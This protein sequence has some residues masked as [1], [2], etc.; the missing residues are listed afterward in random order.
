[1]RGVRL[2]AHQCLR[3][4]WMVFFRPQSFT[5]E[6]QSKNAKE[7][8][9]LILQSLIVT[10]VLPASLTFVANFFWRA[11]GISYNLYDSLYNVI[12]GVGVGIAIG[13]LFSLI[14]E[15][16]IGLS[17]GLSIGITV[18]VT[19][20]L[21]RVPPNDLYL[22]MAVGASLGVAL[23]R[24]IGV[25]GDTAFGVA[26]AR[27]DGVI[28]ALLIGIALSLLFGLDGGLLGGLAFAITSFRLLLLPA[29][30]LSTVLVLF[31]CRRDPKWAPQLFRWSLGFWDEA[32]LLPQPFLPPLLVT[33]GEQNRKT[34]MDAIVHLVE[35]TFQQNAARLALLKL[36]S[37]EL[38]QCQSV[39]QIA[40]LVTTSYWSSFSNVSSGY[41]KRRGALHKVTDLYSQFKNISIEVEKGLHYTSNYQR[42]TLYSRIRKQLQE[43]QQQLI[44]GAHVS[45]RQAFLGIT[46]R[47]LSLIDRE[48]YRL[49]EK[50]QTVEPIP[51][52]YVAPRPLSPG[53]NVFIGRTDV[54]RFIENHILRT[55]QI[56]PIVLHGQPRIGKSSI[57]R[58][59]VAQLP[60][61]TIPVYIDMHMAAQVETTGGLLFN[62][63]DLIAQ[64]LKGREL[65]VMVPELRNY[66][67]EPFI[68]FRKFLD[69]VEQTLSVADSRII[70]ALDEF[71]E[72]EV[73]L[74]EG[75]ISWDFMSFLRSTMQHRQ[76]F[77]LLFAGTHTLDEMASDQWVTY[78]RSAVRCKVS[79]LDEVDARKLIT[80]PIEEFS[81]NYEPEA[82][83]FLLKQTRCHPCLIQL[84]CG[85]LVNLKNE[86]LSRV[87]S[88]ADVQTALMK[89]LETGDY[90]FRGIWEWIPER[91][92]PML[93]LLGALGTAGLEE[94]CNRLRT[95]EAEIRSMIKRL[96][97]V[98]I[99]A[100]D[101]DQRSCRFHV[102][103]LQKWVA[104]HAGRIGV[105]T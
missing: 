82:V 13:I 61:K 48:I 27:I 72:I 45:E 57:L 91:E 2:F 11:V 69:D 43:T 12:L 21:L 67:D 101:N 38:Q 62:L 83:E 68:C 39:E 6:I 19:L 22:S 53:A 92:R 32:M 66:S 93:T 34:G 71:E 89:A 8:R 25:F 46:Q 88:V 75:K 80:N 36:G 100:W 31:L 56:V 90:V 1:M 51:N 30:G 58:Y 16:A 97:E 44:L 84:T 64:T 105:R 103:L 94:L 7:S 24:G 20:A 35:N 18:G 14:F 9:R 52:P 28:G 99:I 102:P 4:P 10:I 87:A 98:E 50:S 37:L 41:G 17:V 60:A 49:T 73:K 78:F 55:T 15:L 85:S 5:N 26:R 42:L 95:P 86:A 65:P 79:Y 54:F 96:V 47:W 23:G 81:L 3:I 40:Q 63:A 74:N 59:L 33:V 77:G 104:S 29:E 76:Y 70:M